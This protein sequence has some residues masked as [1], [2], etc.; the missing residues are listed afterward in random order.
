MQTL[1]AVPHPAADA[2]EH[3]QILYSFNLISVQR[4]ESLTL[5]STINSS[6]KQSA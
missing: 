5:K 1:D 3:Q 4:R 6:S 2:K